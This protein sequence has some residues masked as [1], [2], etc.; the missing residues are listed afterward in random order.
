MN[1]DFREYMEWLPLMV[2][3]VDG[4]LNIRFSNR[5]VGELLGY[6]PEELADVAIARLFAAE[7]RA[8]VERIL[9]EC[10]EGVLPLDLQFR[11]HVLRKSD[12][13]QIPVG[14][15]LN[16]V[17]APDG[18][19][20]VLV[21][22]SDQSEFAQ[23]QEVRDQLATAIDQAGEMVVVT[24]VDGSIEY[25]N[26]AYERTTQYSLY[27]VIG[28]N[29]RILKTDYHDKAYY[30]N[31]W[32]T[33]L[34]GR[35]W[36]G[37]FLNRRKDGTHFKESASISPVVNSQGEIVKFV[38]IKRDVTELEAL[39]RKLRQADKMEAL[40]RMAAVVVHDFNNILQVINGYSQLAQEE[41]EEG[42]VMMQYIDYV[43]EGSRRARSLVDD[44]G[45]FSSSDVRKLERIDLGELVAQIG[46]KIKPLLGAQHRL[47]ILAGDRPVMVD[48]ETDVVQNAIVNLCTNARDAMPDG[49][50]IAI[51]VGVTKKRPPQKGMAGSETLD[52]ACIEVADNGSGI[53][54]EILEKVFDPFFTT[55]SRGQGTGLGLPII[56]S[57]MK[58]Y[59]GFV[60]IETEEGRGTSVSLLI[61]LVSDAEDHDLGEIQVVQ[62]KTKVI[63]RKMSSEACLTV[64]MAEDDGIVRDFTS[65]SLRKAGFK[66]IVT[67]NGEEAFEAFKQRGA[68]IDVVLL[69]IVMPGMLGT[70]VRNAIRQSGSDVPIVFITGYSESHT[71]SD[72]RRLS[73]NERILYKPCDMKDVIATL[74]SLATACK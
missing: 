38:A 29:Q 58:N 67:T 55:K 27:E 42:S 74:K 40:G 62:G 8:G 73:D 25:V 65:K 5:L 44:L 28:R 14:I 52:Y 63:P 10:I 72:L 32:K 2:F 53:A 69:D 7:E 45:S 39:H 26:P 46:D 17:Q 22:M 18:S 13:S 30:D 57:A 43:I 56:Y 23:V 51:R 31:L 34:S 12:S 59:D 49:G 6:S 50:E 20:G 19:S 48:A 54:P 64:L 11:F 61:P 70:D 60:D 68:E 41:A 4:E 24:D 36:R 3:Q 66:L 47:N 33:I 37:E 15:H 21:L 16:S 9:R 1:N 35:T 71:S